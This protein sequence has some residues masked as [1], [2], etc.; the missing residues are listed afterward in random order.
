MPDISFNSIPNNL[1]VPFVAAE[2][3]NSLATQGPALLSYRSLLIGQKTAGGTAAADSLVRVTSADQVLTLAGRGSMLHR[4]AIAYF[5][6]NTFTETSIAVLAD[7][8]AGVQAS[9]TLT[10]TGPATAAGTV[11]LYLGGTLVQVGVASGDSANSIAAA[12]NAAINAN[13]DLPVSSGVSTNVV[14]VTFRHKG[15]VGNNFDLRANYQD[16]ERYPTGVSLAFVAMSGGTT[17]P[18]VANLIANLGDM[19][20]QIWAHPYTD[21]TTL[22][23][24]ENE[25]ASRFGPLRMI[26]GFAITAAVGTQA[27]LGTLG[28]GRN[29]PH[30]EIFAQPGENPLT[31]PME[32]AAAAAAQIALSANADPGRPFQ[33]LALAGDPAR[34]F[35]VLPPAETDLFTITERNLLLGDGIST[36]KAVPGGGVQIERA[37]T[38][39]QTS[40]SG[41][42]DKSYKDATTMLTLLYLRFS[43]RN[44]ILSRYPR[45][46][47][48]NDGGRIGPGQAVLTPNGG[49]G[50]ALAWFREMEEIGLVE[51]FDDFKSNL[52]VQ[53]N[54]L[55]PNRLDFLLPPNLI[56]QLIVSAVK[57]Q[58]RL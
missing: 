16:G 13:L 22:T 55:D 29:S 11:N 47:L 9:G 38:T 17:A 34:S 56:N 1:L 25:L 3:D 5:A 43:F 7:N 20:F 33:T 8:G 52:V 57:L 53:R 23:A 50:E 15:L 35:R 2:I 27:T 19:W 42:T 32:F 14:T 21:A 48:A 41:A 44:R 51:S 18:S 6:N 24:L 40:A 58:F 30:S 4:M 54:S 46:K 28:D 39:Y 45:H 12:I 37:I 49:K 26:D 10:V 31:L 36:S